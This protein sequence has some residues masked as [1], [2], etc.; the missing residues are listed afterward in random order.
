M[1]DLAQ[2]LCCGCTACASICP[3][4]V[5]KMQTNLEGFQ[6]PY[7][8][9]KKMC[10]NCGLCV[11][12]CP[13]LNS[14][15]EHV[16][17]N[18]DGYIVQTRDELVREESASGGAFSAIAEYVLRMG[19]IVY[20]AAYDNEFEVRHIGV[21]NIKDLSRLRHS[22]YVQSNLNGVFYEIKKNLQSGIL[23]CFSGTP[24]QVEGL[25]GFLRKR[26]SNLILIDLCCHGVA[27]PLIWKKYLEMNRTLCFNKIYF[28]W[29]H[30]GYKYSTMSF[31]EN[32][33]EIYFKG[34]ESDPMLRAYFSNNCDRKSCYDCLFKKRYRISDFTI[35]DC[36]Q[37]RF[38][39]KGFDD[40]KG[41]TSVLANTQKGKDI[42][43]NMMAKGLVRA[44][45]VSPDDLV[46]G[47][48]ELV[49]SVKCGKIRDEFF[50]DATVL[51]GNEL[52][53]KYFPITSKQRVKK[54]IRI[55]LLKTG[56]YSFIKYLIYS[57]RRKRG[58]K[59]W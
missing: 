1:I 10:I 26:Y 14:K 38:F 57:K 16:N 35:W 56:L 41:T 39:N 25:V 8:S 27:S 24:C 45:E 6:E 19:G 44:F 3:Q 48:K 15:N 17:K 33:K 49:S 7:I 23:V 43:E 4:N 21:N 31:F 2:N 11:E 34:V 47:N 59:T 40:D 42:I 12:V 52:F 36:F 18:E 58:N 50:K 32:E 51:D 54:I 46:Y 30:Y 9:E 55:I 53:N 37:P 20:G 28:R 13:V 5:I 29:K 22:K